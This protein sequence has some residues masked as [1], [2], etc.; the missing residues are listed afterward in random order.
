MRRILIT[1]RVIT[2]AND[3]A[4]R[5]TDYEATNKLT[6]LKNIISPQAGSANY[7]AYIDYIVANYRDIITA[8]PDQF[9]RYNPNSALDLSKKFSHPK[10]KKDGTTVN[11]SLKFAD[12]IVEFLGYEWVRNHCFPLFMNELGIRTCVYCNAQYGVSMEK[13]KGKGRKVYTSS[14]QIDHFKPKSKYPYLATSFFNLQPSCAHCNQMKLKKDA[15]FQLYTTNQADLV[16]FRFRLTP[17]SIIDSLIM[18]DSEKLEIGFDVR[19]A[20]DAAL[21]ANHENIF[22]ISS[23]YDKHKEEASEIVIQSKI[24]N[25]AYIDQL[26]AEFGLK[27]PHLRKHILN[28]IM[29]F[30]TDEEDINK[31]PLT[32]LRQD[33][34]KQLGLL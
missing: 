6:E 19:D 1:N 3:Y 21:L 30:P 10:Q 22:R 29:G 31:R 24:Y 18:C 26:V 4:N 8:T 16:P 7:V 12:L 15:E 2:L 25:K 14:Y 27:V 33:L 17:S 11:E 9:D 20:K 32:L 28:V 5:L 23:K 34:A 13:P